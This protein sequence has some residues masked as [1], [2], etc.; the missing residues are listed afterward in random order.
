MAS[1]ACAAS[2]LGRELTAG[3][4]SALDT[5]VTAAHR[6]G[7]AAGGDLILIGRAVAEPGF[8]AVAV[9]AAQI[10]QDHR[11]QPSATELSYS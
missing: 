2:I 1:A 10:E 11:Y 6:T 7:D 4:M 5:S 8:E 9:L 3:A